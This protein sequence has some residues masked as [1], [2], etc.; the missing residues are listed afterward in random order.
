MTI[1]SDRSLFPS[2]L[3]AQLTPGG[4]AV[5]CTPLSRLTVQRVELIKRQARER[6]LMI[7]IDG[8]GIARDRNL[9]GFESVTGTKIFS[10][11]FRQRTRGG[12]KSDVT[13]T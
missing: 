13:G 3:Q 9:G 2:I 5:G 10:F 1:E 7:H 8:N 11:S 12:E 6:I 4:N